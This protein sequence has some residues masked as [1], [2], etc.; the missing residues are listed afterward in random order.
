[1]FKDVSVR[2]SDRFTTRARTTTDARRSS[3]IQTAD[4]RMSFSACKSATNTAERS[5]SQVVAASH[6]MVGGLLWLCGVV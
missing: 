2:L 4:Y 3:W 5:Q 6:V 1:M